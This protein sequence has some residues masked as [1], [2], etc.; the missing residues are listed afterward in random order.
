MQKCCQKHS[1]FPAKEIMAP[2]P[3]SV[4][5]R[6]SAVSGTPHVSP[7]VLLVEDAAEVA[8]LMSVAL[9][10]E[11]FDVAV[12]TNGEEALERLASFDPVVIVLDLG[13]PGIDGFETCRR[14]RQMSDVH[15]IMLTARTAE[16]DKLVGFTIGADDY[17]TKPASMREL[18]AR[19]RAVVR[20]RAAVTTA[21]QAIPAALGVSSSPAFVVD[22]AMRIVSIDGRKVTFTRTEFALVQELVRRSDEVVSRLELQSTVWGPDWRGGA[23][24]VDVHLSN[25]RRKLADAGAPLLIHTVRESG[26]RFTLPPA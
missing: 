8:L 15:I 17:V 9:Q 4:E 18:G 10:S 23:H 13:L 2:F 6:T 12:V 25:V 1:V 16:A 7:R 3:I 20:R 21:A 14:I 22:A 11:G 5:P 24:L 19:V 26:Y